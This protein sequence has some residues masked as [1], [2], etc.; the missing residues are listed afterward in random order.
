VIILGSICLL[1]CLIIALVIKL[2]SN[3]PILHASFRVGREGALFKMYKFRSMEI[4]NGG[5]HVTMAVLRTKNGFHTGKL[6]NDPRITPVGRFLR[7][8]CLDELPQLINV[9]KGEMSLV[10]PRPYFNYELEGYSEWQFRRFLMKPGMT[11][12]WQVTGRQKMTMLLDDALSTDVFY[13]DHYNIWMD[14]R[15]LLK[16]LPVVFSGAGK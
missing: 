11:G 15:I 13:T 9:L 10:G 2:T 14:F 3:G 4:N 7:K 5:H 8:Y 12:L 1:P 6:E 16:T